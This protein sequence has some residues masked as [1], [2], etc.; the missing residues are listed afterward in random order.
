MDD[1]TLQIKSTKDLYVLYEAF[2]EDDDEDGNPIFLYSSFGYMTDQYVAYFGKSKLRK[3]DLTAKDIIESLEHVP[4]EDIYPKTPDSI[5]I[6]TIPI[7]NKV[8]FKGP[9]LNT[10]FLG[11]KLLQKLILQEANTMELLARNPHPNIVGYHGCLIKRDRIVGFVLDRYPVTLEERL[12]YSTEIIDTETCMSKIESA[13]N[14]LH[15]LGLAHN[16]LTPMNI[17]VDEKDSPF[18]IDFGSCGPFGA[19]LITAGTP[20]WI[21]EDY[22]VSGAQFDKAALTKIRTWLEKGGKNENPETEYPRT[23]YPLR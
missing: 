5:T 4:D 19:T 17:M 9:K 7:D 10:A 11:T 2:S 20:G 13:I 1:Q 18:L 15:S 16:D 12:K 21:D 23:G 6:A 22:I 3:Y 8:F 14:H